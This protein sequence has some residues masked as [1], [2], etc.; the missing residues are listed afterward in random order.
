MSLNRRQFLA[1]AAST[2]ALSACSG[3]PCF[4]LEEDEPNY[5]YIL[6]AQPQDIELIEG[7]LTPALCFNGNNPAPTIRAKQGQAVRILF[8][9]RL[10]EP[11]TIHWHGLR[12]PIE[13]DGVPFL[14]QPPI[15]PGED[16][17]YE[18]TPPD[19]GTFWY[20]PHMNSLE[21]L[22][23][24]L[25][26]AIIVE[27]ANDLGF[28][29]EQVF[30]LKNWHLNKDGSFA[31]F[32][33]PRNAARMGTPGSWETVNGKVKP[34]V[35]VACGSVVRLRF[36][37]IDN[38]VIYKLA[39]ENSQAMVV[40]VDGN[41][42]EKPV[43]LQQH[44]IA[45]GMRLDIAIATPNKPGETIKVKNGKGRLLFDLV[46]L[47][48]S[49]SARPNPNNAIPALPLNPITMPDLTHAEQLNFLFEWEG[50]VT[51]A[52]KDG[53]AN[54][55]FWTINRRAWEGMSADNIP[56]PVADL[57]LGKTYIFNLRNV[58]PHS[59]PIH[60]HGF[61]WLVLNSNKKKIIPY[62]TDTVLLEKNEVVQVAFVADNP[63]RWMYHCHVIEHM[64]T[65]LMGYIRVA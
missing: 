22:G 30:L 45:P 44:K 59:H 24:G 29:E 14:S 4:S 51:P 58:T 17:L 36:L 28:D 46:T 18:F 42:I 32:T 1:S 35:E 65:G 64:K 54:P 41:P 3:I 38:T 13:M 27:E 49:G 43:P 15:Q 48:T 31:P 55:K 37:N 25:A 52:S 16:F 2:F 10:K 34:V 61:T 62:H 21:Q 53:K 9:N 39:V 40:A 50:A 6:T 11:T 57:K 19:A 60:M 26:G 56:E 23:K 47:K 8:R 12:I 63:G 5:D 20:H 33:S 7:T